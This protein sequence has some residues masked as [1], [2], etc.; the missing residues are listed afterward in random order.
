MPA[1]SPAITTDRL[2]LRPH[3]HSWPLRKVGL[4]SNSIASS[5]TRARSSASKAVQSRALIA[6]PRRLACARRSVERPSGRGTG[7]EDGRWHGCSRPVCERCCSRFCRVAEDPRDVGTGSARPHAVCPERVDPFRQAHEIIPNKGW[8]PRGCRA[9]DVA[10]DRTRR[11]GC[12]ASRPA[13]AGGARGCGPGRVFVAARGMLPTGT[14]LAASGLLGHISPGD[15]FAGT[16]VEARLDIGPEQSGDRASMKLLREGRH[17]RLLKHEQCWR[18]T[19]LLRQG[20]IGGPKWKFF[21]RANR[22]SASPVHAR[23][24]PRRRAGAW[25]RPTGRSKSSTV[26]VLKTATPSVGRKRRSGKMHI[27]GGTNDV[28]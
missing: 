19:T 20:D 16:D 13:P 28:N 1:R 15:R 25:C 27:V 10:V 24:H 4:P 14:C 12:W 6:A 17:G 11:N 2:P 8:T 26:R 18:L 7:D 21:S 3:R 23:L 5:G 22:S 9:L